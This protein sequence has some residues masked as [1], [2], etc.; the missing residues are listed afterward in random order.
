MKAEFA[1]YTD[2]DSTFCSSLPLI[3]ARYPN[4]DET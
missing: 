1:F 3:Q 4:F 2:T